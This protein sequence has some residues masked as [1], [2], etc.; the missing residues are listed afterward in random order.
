MQ[1]FGRLNFIASFNEGYGFRVT[2]LISEIFVGNAS[3]MRRC[4]DS[5]IRDTWQLSVKSRAAR[6]LGF[7]HVILS[8]NGTPLKFNQVGDDRPISLISDSSA[9]KCRILSGP[10]EFNC[11]EDLPG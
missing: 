7:T 2:N 4:Q 1:L 8:V 6:F 9:H 3:L 5:L 11:F 10:A